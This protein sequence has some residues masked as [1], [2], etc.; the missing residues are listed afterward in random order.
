MAPISP[1][2]AA[3]GPEKVLGVGG[4]W[5]FYWFGCGFD[6]VG[7]LLGMGTDEREREKKK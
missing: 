4:Q 5:W 3:T 1:V 2:Q 6:G 7:R